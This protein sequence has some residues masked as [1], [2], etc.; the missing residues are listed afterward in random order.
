MKHRKNWHLHRRPDEHGGWW[1]Y[2]AALFGSIVD[3]ALETQDDAKAR[4]LRD[5]YDELYDQERRDRRLGRPPVP[6]NES[7]HAK[8]GILRSRQKVSTV[9]EVFGAYA[10]FAA[11]QRLTARTI[12]NV[13][14]SLLLILR[15][16][17]LATGRETS[18]SALTDEILGTYSAAVIGARTGPLDANR[19]RQTVVSTIRQARS[20]FGADARASVH[21]RKL[22]LPDTLAGFMSYAP[23]RP[24][25]QPEARISALAAEKLR[26]LRATWQTTDAARYLALVLLR[27]LA[28]RAGEA[29]HA[30]WD[31][32]TEVATITDDREAPAGVPATCFEVA[33][34]ITDE[35]APKGRARRWVMDAQE[36]AAWREALKM[37]FSTV[38]EILGG[39]MK[40]RETLLEHLRTE[41]RAIGIAKDPKEKVLHKL[42]KQHATIVNAGLERARERLGHP[43]AAVTAKHYILGS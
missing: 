9:A 18:A 39:T 8:L 12:S 13:Q 42:R 25:H 33:V 2:R 3:K 24:E 29:L 11:E 31:W 22:Y 1:Y 10:A 26:E 7:V 4:E 14:T 37:R 34:V 35:F 21:Y 15:R 28:F 23:P 32:V 38:P 16:A 20:L 5:H 19:G 17:G 43:D 30:R 41:L 40:D 36:S 27:D 6:V